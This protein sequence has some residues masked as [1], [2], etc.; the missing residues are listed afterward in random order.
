MIECDACDD[1]SALTTRPSTPPPAP[2]A[3]PAVSGSDRR[4]AAY[5]P[6]V[7]FVAVDGFAPNVSA[8]GMSAVTVVPDAGGADDAK[9]SAKCANP[10]RESVQAASQPAIGTPTAVVG[11]LDLELCIVAVHAHPH[12]L[13]VRILR[14]VR[15][16]F[17]DDVV[18]RRL[19]LRRNVLRRVDLDGSTG[20]GLR[21]ASASTAARR[22]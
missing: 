14:S 13:G 19:D 6:C 18:G 10:I 16:G 12:G 1:C 8:I 9:M 4:T 5:Y 22:P 2:A 21:R 3:P 11:D 17:R 7:P 15:E 20:T